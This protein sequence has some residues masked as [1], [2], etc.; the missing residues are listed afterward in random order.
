MSIRIVNAFLC[1]RI[2]QDSLGKTN[3]FGLGPHQF[4]PKEYPMAPSV[5]TYCMWVEADHS[6]LGTHHTFDL[7]I[8]DEHG[9]PEWKANAQIKFTEDIL[10]T[11]Q[12]LPIKISAKKPG[13]KQFIAKIDGKCVLEIPMQFLEVNAP[14]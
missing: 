6:E 8:R 14:Q 1:E 9:H 5:M 2:E 11:F 4:S 3:A 10:R 12:S 13:L 7:E